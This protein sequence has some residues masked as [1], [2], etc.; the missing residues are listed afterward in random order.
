MAGLRN[1]F[2]SLIF[3]AGLAAFG[4]SVSPAQLLE[5]GS[6][7]QT[8]NPLTDS[9][10]KP[11]K[12]QLFD[13]EA[14]FAKDVAERGG[15]AFA[16]WFADDGVELGNPARVFVPIMMKTEMTPH[17]DGLKDRRRRLSWVTAYGRLKPGVNLERAQLSLQP[18]MQV[19]AIMNPL[20][21]L[22][23]PLGMG[24]E[25]NPLTMQGVRKKH[26]GG[27]PRNRNSGVL[28]QARPLEQRRLQRHR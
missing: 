13:L 19:A 7:S 11:G 14:R 6:T 15:A 5:P 27:K 24:V 23:F 28:Q 4:S 8:P 2:S 20:H 10:I 9:T 21:V 12:M 17:S 26:F 22:K 18:L 25:V 3:I 1:L 16:S